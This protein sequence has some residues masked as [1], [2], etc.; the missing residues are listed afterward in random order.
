MNVQD[1]TVGITTGSVTVG[2]TACIG[3]TAG[4]RVNSITLQFVSGATCTLVGSSTLSSGFAL[5]ATLPLL[6]EGPATF[7]LN[8]L[9]ASGSL[10]QFIKHLNGAPEF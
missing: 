4:P 8:S 6:I 2:G 9:G 3:F 1:K 7:H 5:S 10:V